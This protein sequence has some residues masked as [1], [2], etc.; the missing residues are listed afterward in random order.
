[1]QVKVLGL[2]I[3]VSMAVT[4]VAVHGDEERAREPVVFA[5]SDG[6]CYA[7]SV[8]LD[9]DRDTG[10]T[11]VYWAKDSEGTAVDHYPWYAWSMHLHCGYDGSAIYIV[12]RG[13]WP[14][15]RTASSNHLALGFY[16]AGEVIAEHSTLDIAG[17]AEN[18]RPSVSHY[19]VFD[20]IEGIRWCQNRVL[21]LATAVDG[22]RLQFEPAIG[23]ME[24]V[25]SDACFSP[26]TTE[27]AR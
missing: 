24:V 2:A 26:R 17:E 4:P 22:R 14:R 25:E 3:V 20:S 16:A 5:S 11:S 18:V 23:T 8:A 19:R 9:G 21:F 15:G 12:R 1:M 27:T 7:R 13:H 6:R 10:H